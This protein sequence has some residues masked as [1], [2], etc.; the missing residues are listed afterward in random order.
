L[1]NAAVPGLLQ[2]RR[3]AVERDAPAY[4]CD[5]V[6]ALADFDFFLVAGLV[7]LNVLAAALRSAGLFAVFIVFAASL[8]VSGGTASAAA[9]A[10][11]AAV[12]FA[13]AGFAVAAGAAFF[14]GA[15]AA[16]FGA[17]FGSAAAAFAAL[18][19]AVLRAGLAGA[20]GLAAFVVLAGAR[21]AMA[22]VRRRFVFSSLIVI[23]FLDRVAAGASRG[24]AD[25]R[26]DAARILNVPASATSRGR[27]PYVN[28]KPAF[29]VMFLAQIPGFAPQQSVT[30]R[31]DSGTNAKSSGPT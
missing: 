29:N 10:F 24:H 9:A 26:P 18:G 1:A 7:A 16:V 8:F 6:A 25:P 21:T 31:S 2:A 11:G 15:L 13:A 27:V 28:G 5:Q 4:R 19:A 20:A 17:A 30:Y 3:A 12:F 22:C 23:A 14:A